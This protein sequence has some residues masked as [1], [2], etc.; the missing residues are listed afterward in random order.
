MSEERI[1]LSRLWDYGPRGPVH[2]GRIWNIAPPPEPI[3]MIGVEEVPTFQ[4]F[5]Y[6]QFKAEGDVLYGKWSDEDQWQ[7]VG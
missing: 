4:K 3:M 1:N 2:D 6:G 7:R 5:V